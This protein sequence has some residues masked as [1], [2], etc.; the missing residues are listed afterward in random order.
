MKKLLK[1]AERIRSQDGPSHCT[2]SIVHAQWRYYQFGLTQAGLAPRTMLAPGTMLS[3][4]FK[5][6]PADWKTFV[7]TDT[8]GTATYF[9]QWSEKSHFNQEMYLEF[10]REFDNVAKQLTRLYADKG[11]LLDTEAKLATKMA[12]YVIVQ[13]AAGAAPR[14]ATHGENELLGLL[15]SGRVD[16]A[17]VQ[18]ALAR[19]D[20][21]EIFHALKVA[22]IY[23]QP[24][25]VVAALA[26]ASAEKYL[27][28]KNVERN[29]EPA[30]RHL[31]LE[32]TPE[33]LLSLALGSLENLEY[34]LRKNVAVDAANGFG[35]T[36]LFYAVGSNNHSAAEL[37]LR[38]KADVNH[39]YKSVKE[40]RPN[41]DE[42][43]Y[44]GLRHTRRST[45]MHA[46][47]NSDVRMLKILLQAGASLQSRDDLGFNAH[48]YA[49][50]GKSRENAN[51]LASLGLEPA[52]PTYSSQPDPAVREQRILATLRIDGYVKHLVIPP[53]R[54]DLLV[55]SVVP[56]DK[57]DGGPTDGIYLISIA[58][59]GA[60]RIVGHLPR[61]YAR[62]LAV[63]PDGKRIYIIEMSHQ[64]S[65]PAKKYGLSVIDTS[66]PTKPM[67]I[68]LVEGDFMTM[69]LSSNGRELYLQERSLK[70]AFSRGLIAFETG[71]G[72]PVL[73]CSNP[74]GKTAYDRPVF[75]YGFAS[76]PDEPLLVIVDQSRSL[77]LF[78][79][80]DLCTPKKLMEARF[81]DGANPMFGGSGR[82]LV[83]R[84]LKKLRLAST[85]EVKASYAASSSGSFHVNNATDLTTAEFDKDIVVIR[86]KP[87]GTYVLTD[88]F[89]TESEHIGSVTSSDSGYIYI[90]WKGGISVGTVPLH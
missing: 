67:V 14:D 22:L 88:R 18:E 78:E 4:S 51:Y 79:A 25:T 50:M 83:I 75:A 42:C 9:R 54:L 53:G 44:S 66:N 33:P 35:K 52:A 73:K 74:F 81:E 15:R 3:D 76:F 56:W 77:L 84:G 85:L 61:I 16:K 55:A 87:S 21:L 58:V 38:Y 7:E 29:T 47:Q 65:P 17:K 27:G 41:D 20:S 11:S 5:A 89:R 30:N 39:T 31:D 2:G 36:A 40:L 34:L 80:R 28:A 26:D 23:N 72:L 71:A 69:H 32:I 63:S 64:G 8:S 68:G 10:V 12:L 86:T 49:L 70:P 24:H 19:L 62:D 59:P 45:L 43:T 60:P 90:G 13:R 37:L 46:A 6:G 48:D 1:M 82:T 57:L